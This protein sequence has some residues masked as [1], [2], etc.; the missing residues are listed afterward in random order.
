M[1][2]DDIGCGLS[3]V[4]SP[5]LHVSCTCRRSLGCDSL[6]EYAFPIWYKLSSNPLVLYIII[7]DHEVV[8]KSGTIEEISMTPVQG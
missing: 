1:H 5:A 4:E 2:W 7:E 3:L 8:C 6:L